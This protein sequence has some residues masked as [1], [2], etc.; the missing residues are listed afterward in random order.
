MK[1]KKTCSKEPSDS[2]FTVPA[3]MISHC[4]E[5]D[6]YQTF[7][8]FLPAMLV[9]LCL[10]R[11]I[12]KGSAHLPAD[13]RLTS[14]SYSSFPEEENQR[15][16]E[17]TLRNHG[18]WFTDQRN[19]EVL[20]KEIEREMLPLYVRHHQ[21]ANELALYCTSLTFTL[22]PHLCIQMYSGENNYLILLLLLIL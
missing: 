5:H 1:K 15:Q 17:K 2:N 7:L 8:L 9:Q 6:N 11:N 18:I 19:G 4:V 21:A 14:L 16:A 3:K 13:R 22:W 20:V 12:C 10:K